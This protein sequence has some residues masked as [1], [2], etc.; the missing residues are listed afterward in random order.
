YSAPM[1]L[2]PAL[3]G[4]NVCSRVSSNIRNQWPSVAGGYVSQILAI[5]H[6][7][8]NQSFGI[9]FMATNDFGGAG[10]LR[11]TS[12][13]GLT[14]Y[15][16]TVTRELTFRFGLQGGVIQR[17]VNF[18]DLLFADQIARGGS[19]PTLENP[20]RNVLMIDF[21]SGG[22]VFYKKYFGGLA[23]HH[24]TQPNES[25]ME[26]EAGRPI[27]LSI[28]GGGKFKIGPKVDDEEKQQ[29]YLTPT[30]NYRAQLQF[31]QFDVGCYYSKYIFN[32]G[33]WYRGIPGFKSYKE[34]Y[35]NND[36]VCFVFG[37]SKDRV[38]VGYSY[39]YTI[40]WLQGNT[41]GSHELSLSYQFCKLKR[42]KKKAI[43]V[44]CPKF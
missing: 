25:L 39:D 34:G 18:N 17:S 28:H 14:A 32:L 1:Y 19:V 38:N 37:I 10:R 8:I 24:I 40:S 22:I 30:F 35:P 27:K 31:D 29:M 20:T 43:K 42:K 41:G 26:D 5:D 21:S 13:S 16:L 7:L 11:S 12:F 9:G 15:E 6:F 2:N 3:T 36:A 33:L 44:I 23:I 4:F